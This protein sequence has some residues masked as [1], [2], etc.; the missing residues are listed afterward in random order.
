MA[1]FAM[2][3]DFYNK[4]ILLVYLCTFYYCL[5]TGRL[6]FLHVY[7]LK[8]TP[9]NFKIDEKLACISFSINDSHFDTFNYELSM[10]TKYINLFV[11]ILCTGTVLKTTAI[12][13]PCA[14]ILYLSYLV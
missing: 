10:T 11:N 9:L 12:Q 13:P 4:P 6:V 5:N 3:A 8:T 14:D 7:K 1:E 2:G